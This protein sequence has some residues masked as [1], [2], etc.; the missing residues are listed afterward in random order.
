MRNKEPIQTKQTF[1]GCYCNYSGFSAVLLDKLVHDEDYIRFETAEKRWTVSKLVKGEPSF[2]LIEKE[3]LAMKTE[4]KYVG[5]ILI[6][7]GFK[8]LDNVVSYKLSFREIEVDSIS[9]NFGSSSANADIFS[10]I[11]LVQ[12]KKLA[13]TKQASPLIEEIK[14]YNPANHSNDLS[15]LMIAIKTIP[16]KSFVNHLLTS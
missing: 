3:L 13:F 4:S 14:F 16:S 2:D 10:L 8:F 15:A 7:K 1:I 6:N 9:E 11:A 5:S 12:D